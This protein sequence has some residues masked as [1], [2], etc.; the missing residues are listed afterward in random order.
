LIIAF[1]GL[2]PHPHVPGKL[3]EDASQ[4]IAHGDP[5]VAATNLANA[6]EYFPWRYD[7]NLIAGRLAM[8]AGDSEATIQYLERPGTISQLSPDDLILLG[9]AYSQ[10]GDTLMAEAIWKHASEVGDSMLANQR[11]AALYLQRQ[12]Y[13]SA[14]QALENLLIEDPTDVSLYYQIGAFYAITDPG[15]A[16]PFLAQAE[17]MD[18]ENATHA[19][20]LHD[21]IRTA[22]L[23]DEPS[24]TLLI[25]G[26][27]LANWGKWDLAA[28]AFQNAIIL[29]PDYADAWALMGETRQQIELSK[30][31]A[32][33][34]SGYYELDHALQLDP[35]STLANTFMGLYY[36]RQEEFSQA[37]IYLMQAIASSPEDPY[38]YAELASILA[39]IGDLPAAQLAYESAIHLAPQEPLFY[40]LL[41]EFAMRHQIQIREL[42]LP[43][44]RQAIKLDPSNANTLD[45]MAQ[46]MLMLQ[47]Y[48][49]AKRYAQSALR[50]DPEFASAYLHLGTAYLYLGESDLAHHW[51]QLAE[52]VN[53]DSWIAAQA[54]RMLEYYFP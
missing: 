18:A 21:K 7:L 35:T 27:Q 17:A 34:R 13:P 3:L 23:F 4:A 32:N 38:L 43:A 10:S 6:A 20:M 50:S 37:Q 28:K 36:E 1:L 53:P 54:K 33:S 40:R 2:A 52:T 39:K 9:D 26:R 48:H 47:D 49:S 42:A 44:I 16:L 8:Q 41:A 14:I 25:V 30:T 51:L 24:Y 22:S 11:L 46:A 31:G 29:R 12:D 5:G 15:K 45:V 19:Q